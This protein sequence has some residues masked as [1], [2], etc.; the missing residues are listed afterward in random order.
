M[1]GLNYRSFF[2]SYAEMF[3]FCHICPKTLT[4]SPGKQVWK[5]YTHIIDSLE[6]EKMKD[7]GPGL[8]CTMG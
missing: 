1:L 7:Q 4:N 8:G 5:R 2:W 3:S 6:A